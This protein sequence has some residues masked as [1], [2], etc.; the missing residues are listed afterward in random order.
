MLVFEDQF[1]FVPFVKPQAGLED[2]FT[3]GHGDAD[4]DGEEEGGVDVVGEEAG[5]LN[6]TMLGTPFVRSLEQLGVQGFVRDYAFLHVY[7]TPTVAILTVR[8]AHVGR[9]RVVRGRGTWVPPALTVW[10]RGVCGHASAPGGGRVVHRA[11]GVRQPHVPG[12]G[13][14]CGVG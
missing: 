10:H 12:E 14:V 4:A 13:R 5:L 3:G 8:R 6:G 11:P 2:L 7:M 1:A 9:C